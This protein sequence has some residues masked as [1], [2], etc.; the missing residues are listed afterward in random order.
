MQ[1]SRNGLSREI[2]DKEN[3]FST[4]FNSI[5]NRN[6]L[7]S[8]RGPICYPRCRHRDLIHG[9]QISSKD[10]TNLKSRAADIGSETPCKLLA[11]SKTG[12]R[13]ESDWQSFQG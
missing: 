10:L 1:I 7:K 9:D 3:C 2:P 8:D 4:E 6:R 12:Q 5:M 13:L 11:N